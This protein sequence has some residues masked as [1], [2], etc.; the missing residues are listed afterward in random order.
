MS[1]EHRCIA[2]RHDGRWSDPCYRPGV[3]QIDGHWYCKPHAAGRRRRAANEVRW[4]QERHDEQAKGAALDERLAALWLRLDLI[5]RR[6]YH[7]KGVSMEQGV[8]RL[9]DLEALADRLEAEGR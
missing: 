1:D 5:V 4:K 9:D 7:V 8:V 6:H 3:E 2:L